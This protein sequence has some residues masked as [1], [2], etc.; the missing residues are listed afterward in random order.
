MPM[1][2]RL[3]R[4]GFAVV[5]F[6]ARAEMRDTACELGA[7]WAASAGAA[8]DGVDVLI[9]ML[10][11]PDEVSAAIPRWRDACVPTRPGSI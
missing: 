4:A 3:V 10:P 8:A 2:A 11:G 6:D 7:G 1:C 5:A 9:T